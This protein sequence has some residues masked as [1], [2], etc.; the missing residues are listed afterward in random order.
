MPKANKKPKTK[1]GNAAYSV[2]SRLLAL[3]PFRHKGAV[4]TVSAE[5]PEQSPEPIPSTRRQRR[6]GDITERKR[7]TRLRLRQPRKGQFLSLAWKFGIAT[8]GL[9][10]SAV[11][12]ESYFAARPQVAF[13]SLLDPSD[14]FSAPFT[15]TN[16][17]TISSMN[18]VTFRCVIRKVQDES[19]GGVVVAPAGITPTGLNIPEIGPGETSTN[20]CPFPFE[21]SAPVVAADLEII[22]KYRPDWIPWER[23]KSFR[24]G[25]VKNKDGQMTWMPRATSE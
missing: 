17:G 1:L 19:G 16:T 7:K 13:S 20:G 25:V 8:V 21:L 4:A 22:V 12:V 10:A 14:P 2:S 11:G 18:N 5:Q 9:V 3:I 6:R 15:I 24:F 23:E